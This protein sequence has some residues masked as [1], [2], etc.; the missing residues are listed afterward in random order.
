MCKTVQ[1][2]LYLKRD[3]MITSGVQGCLYSAGIPVHDIIK[4]TEYVSEI[5]NL[6]C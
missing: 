3:D 2:P 6:K 4:M 5:I 1:L